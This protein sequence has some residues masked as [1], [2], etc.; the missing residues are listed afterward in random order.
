M[1]PNFPTDDPETERMKARSRARHR[2]AI[3]DAIE[4]GR[5]VRQQYD[6]QLAENGEIGRDLHGDLAHAVLELYM[7]IHVYED[8]AD[9][10]PDFDDLRHELFHFDGHV[11]DNPETPA[12]L[13][14]AHIDALEATALK[15][16]F[17]EVDEQ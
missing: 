2:Q 11:A 16:G 1:N 13:L 9:R 12:K 6:E 15:L 14:A 17:T 3:A 10:F 7:Q 4:Q 8:A 5:I